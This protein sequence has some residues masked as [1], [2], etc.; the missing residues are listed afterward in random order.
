MQIC[1]VSPVFNDWRS[2]ALLLADLSR[3]F[4]DRDFQVDVIAVDDSST[5]PPSEVS[6]V[7]LKEC[8]FQSFSII[9]LRANVGHQAAIAAALFH[10]S[11][12]TSFDAIL[13]VS[14]PTERIRLLML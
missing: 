7:L 4:R 9:R 12:A 1:L 2:F 5:E 13:V 10:L 3:N 11:E 14:I 6:A 8:A